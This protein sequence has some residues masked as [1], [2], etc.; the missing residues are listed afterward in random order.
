[1]D[2]CGRSG[3]ADAWGRSGIADSRGCSGSTD[4]RGRSGGRCRGVG[5][6][7][8]DTWG[9]SG[10]AAL[11]GT[12]RDEGGLDGTSGDEGGHLRGSGTGLGLTMTGGLAIPF[13]SGLRL[14]ATGGGFGIW[15]LDVSAD[16][17]DIIDRSST[18]ALMSVL[19][20]AHFQARGYTDFDADCGEL[21]RAEDCRLVSTRARTLPRHRKIPSLQHNPVV[22][23]R[24]M[25]W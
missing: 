3:S 5:S 14:A 9:R 24:S 10:S 13:A 12:S 18:F 22:S 11:D 7:G 8:T 20:E 4:A 15:G 19:L 1:M 21:E 25:G 17:T 16:L 23:G 6:G 2:A